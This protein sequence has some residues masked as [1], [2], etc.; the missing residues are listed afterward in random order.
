MAQRGSTPHAG[1]EQDATGLRDDPRA[2]PSPR[3]VRLRRTKLAVHAPRRHEAQ[4]MRDE[5]ISAH[6]RGS[7]AT[8]AAH[9]ANGIPSETPIADKI[10]C[11][12]GSA[13]LNF[14][15]AEDRSRWNPRK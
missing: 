15:E 9:D 6:G 2:R 14:G 8:D 1:R 13:A 11:A 4:D 7:A 5:A 10:V 12:R 3:C